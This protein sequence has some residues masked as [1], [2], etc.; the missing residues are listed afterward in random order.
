MT[1]QD[2]DGSHIKGLAINLF[3]AEWSTLSRVPGFMCFM[4]TPIVKAHKGTQT[5][6]FYNDGDYNVWKEQN[7]TSGWK[8]KYYKGLGTSTGKEFKEY[9]AEKKF[10]TLTHEGDATTNVIDMVFNK[11]RPDDRKDWLGSYDRGLYLDTNKPAISVDEFVHRD[12]IHYSKYDCDR[13]IPNLMDGFKISLRK[14]MFSAFKKPLT[15]RDQGRP[16]VGL[17]VGALR[18]PSWRGEPQWRDRG[19]GAELCRVQQHQPARSKRPVRDALAGREGLS[20]REIHLHPSQ[21][22]HAQDIP[23]RQ[24][25]TSFDTWTTTA[26]P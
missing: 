15:K 1:D 20:V 2:L 10:V 3:E 19:A 14:I 24:T 7:D 21:W 5:R 26:C 23:F 18:L 11:K 22:D 17:C 25:T 8:I 16:A 4:N 9:F 12:L 6:V 13:S